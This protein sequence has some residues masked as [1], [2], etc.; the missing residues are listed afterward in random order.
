MLAAIKARWQTPEFESSSRRGGR[1]GLRSSQVGKR[2]LATPGAALRL[3]QQSATGLEG[4]APLMHQTA[5][6]PVETVPLGGNQPRPRSQ[7]CRRDTKRC[8][9]VPR[10]ADHPAALRDQGVA[11]SNP[12][13]PTQKA[14]ERLGKTDRSGAFD[15][16]SG[17]SAPLM[18][19][20]AHISE[21]AGARSG[22]L[23]VLASLWNQALVQLVPR[24]AD[25]RQLA[26]SQGVGDHDAPVTGPRQGLPRGSKKLPMVHRPVSQSLRSPRARRPPR[27]RS[28]RA[29]DRKPDRL[30]VPG[31]RRRGGVAHRQRPAAQAARGSGREA[32][33]RPVCEPR[34]PPRLT[35]VTSLFDMRPIIVAIA[36]PN[37]AGKSAFYEAHL[38][39]AGLRFVHT[40]EFSRELRVDA[41]QDRRARHPMRNGFILPGS[42]RTYFGDTHLLREF[43]D[44][45]RDPT[46]QQMWEIGDG[47]ATGMLAFRHAYPRSYLNQF[48]HRGTP[49]HRRVGPGAC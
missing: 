9:P 35:H 26:Q 49:H 43:R 23:S 33:G 18:H 39:P 22:P 24:R 17:A 12:V 46:R 31:S 40:D 42:D 14:L 36:G 28:G 44:R 13:S 16:E 1:V 30:G 27:R 7:C 15:F 5:S 11:G 45:W 10:R 37:G 38:E 3:R 34:V 21:A 47:C 6:H 32:H 48:S 8:H 20:T 2:S 41:Y 25:R 19:Q 29:V 4:P